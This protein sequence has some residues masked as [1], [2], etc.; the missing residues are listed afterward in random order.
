MPFDISFIA[1]DYWY[2]LSLLTENE[3]LLWGC[4]CVRAVVVVPYG[5]EM[6]HV[7]GLKY[8]YKMNGFRNNVF[9]AW[10]YCLNVFLIGPFV[11]A[12]VQLNSLSTVCCISLSRPLLLA[13]SVHIMNKGVHSALSLPQPE[14]PDNNLFTRVITLLWVNFSFS[15]SFAWWKFTGKMENFLFTQLI[16]VELN[17]FF[18]RYTFFFVLFLWVFSFSVSI[19]L[20]RHEH[21]TTNDA[22]LFEIKTLYN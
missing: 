17:Y 11:W 5:G 1:C 3:Y 21:T 8:H 20:T 18:E 4:R 13:R 12:Y 22:N 7:K 9:I 2:N 10:V 16:N 14:R 15:S 19:R 6:K